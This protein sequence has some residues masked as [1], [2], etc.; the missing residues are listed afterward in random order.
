[1]LPGWIDKIE[2]LILFTGRLVSWLTFAMVLTTFLVVLLRY[3]FETGSIALQESILYMHAL[4]FLVGAAYT[5]K[6]N[7]HVRVDIFYQ[8]FSETQRAW[9]D[10]LGSLFLLLPSMSF[11]IYISWDYVTES[12]RVLES[13]REAGGLPGVYLIKTVII[14]MAALMLLQGLATSLRALHT[15]QSKSGNA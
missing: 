10:L 11:I 2:T 14:V 1:M 5:L 7:A 8:K 13:S 3:L 6:Q 12:W 9:V 4:I 15:I